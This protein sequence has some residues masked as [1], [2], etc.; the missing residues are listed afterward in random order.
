MQ[1]R[2]HGLSME[3]EHFPCSKMEAGSVYSPSAF[4]ILTLKTLFNLFP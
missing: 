4:L 3:L 1:F 2:I